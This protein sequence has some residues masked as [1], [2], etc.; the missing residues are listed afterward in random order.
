MY[1]NVAV[2]LLKIS[3]LLCEFGENYGRKSFKDG[4]WTPWTVLFPS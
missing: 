4:P 1:G 2:T 3:I